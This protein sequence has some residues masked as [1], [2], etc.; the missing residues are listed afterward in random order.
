LE[1]VFIKDGLLPLLLLLLLLLRGRSR[2]HVHIHAL[3][4]AGSDAGRFIAEQWAES[5]RH[6][7]EH[8]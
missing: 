7:G 6:N 2:I 4:T 3:G 1:A 5:V 8:K